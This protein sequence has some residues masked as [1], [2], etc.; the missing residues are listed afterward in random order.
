MRARKQNPCEF[1]ITMMDAQGK[2]PTTE[3]SPR[4]ETIVSDK[5]MIRMLARWRPQSWP[6]IHWSL[7]PLPL[8]LAAAPLRGW[9]LPPFTSLL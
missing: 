9:R 2:A 6:L 7:P 3:G 8:T 1:V 4:D 5:E